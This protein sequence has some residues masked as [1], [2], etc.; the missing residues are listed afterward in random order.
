MTQRRSNRGLW[1]R[2]VRRVTVASAWVVRKALQWWTCEWR[3][4]WWGAIVLFLPLPPPL[5][6]LFNVPH[7]KILW[8]TL[9]PLGWSFHFWPK[10]NGVASYN[11][12]IG[13]LRR[14]RGSER[15][16]CGWADHLSAVWKTA[17]WVLLPTPSTW[18]LARGR[19]RNTRSRQQRCK[20]DGCLLRSEAVGEFRPPQDSNLELLI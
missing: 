8:K 5:L 3:P 7:P 19:E 18:S 17:A 9:V 15:D 13:N 11:V 2:S 1:C 6:L 10:N 4:E 20:R 16:H 12:A 14:W